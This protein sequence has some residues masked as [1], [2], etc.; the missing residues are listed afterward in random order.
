MS[1]QPAARAACARPV[2]LETEIRGPD[3]DPLSPWSGTQHVVG[4]DGLEHLLCV[5]PDPSTCSPPCTSA[6][7]VCVVPVSLLNVNPTLQ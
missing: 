5:G 1:L 7:S 2:C 6:G 4:A 3:L